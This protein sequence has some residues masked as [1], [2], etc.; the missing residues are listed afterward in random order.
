MNQLQE[1]LTQQQDEL[2]SFPKNQENVRPRFEQTS[3]EV[4]EVNDDIAVIWQD[5]ADIY[6]VQQRFQKIWQLQENIKELMDD[7][8]CRLLPQ[9]YPDSPR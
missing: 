1:Q 7:I 2:I 6:D 4:G 8:E 5:P 3:E 9:S